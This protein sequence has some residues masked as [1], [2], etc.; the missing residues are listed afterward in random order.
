MV[1]FVVENIWLQNINEPGIG[2]WLS[3]SNE[4]LL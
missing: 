4:E 1:I 3:I 2:L